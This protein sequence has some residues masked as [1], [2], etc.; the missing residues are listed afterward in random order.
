MVKAKQVGKLVEDLALELS[1]LSS[2]KRLYEED[3][4]PMFHRKKK[5]SAKYSVPTKRS[6]H[7][8]H[9]AYHGPPS[10]NRVIGHYPGSDNAKHISHSSAPGAYT[11]ATVG[12]RNLTQIFHGTGNDPSTRQRNLVN[13]RGARI[14]FE[15]Y[16]N[17]SDP[18]VFQWAVVANK[19]NSGPT[20]PSAVEFLRNYGATSRGLTLSGSLT[21]NEIN[22]RPINSDIWQVL[23]HR[24]Y[25]IAGNNTTVKSYGGSTY[26]LI[27]EYVPI[28]TQLRYP[29]TSTSTPT[30]GNVFLVWWYGS[31]AAPGGGQPGNVLTLSEDHVAFFRETL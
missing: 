16:N 21:S 31:F 17:H 5:P 29:D 15:V 20:T 19:Q 2:A 28:K 11:P 10:G 18:V 12:S 23:R 25:L 13:Y 8:H 22:C 6:K 7:S 14:C 4:K 24:R 27:K 1:G 26:R 3:V 30:T 9:G